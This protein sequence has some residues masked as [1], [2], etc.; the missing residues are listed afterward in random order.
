[1]RIALPLMLLFLPAIVRA[2]PSTDGLVVHFRAPETWTDVRIHFW[3]TQPDGPATRWPGEAMTPEGD[4]WYKLSLPGRR[5]ARFVISAAGV[6]RLQTSDL[7]ADREDWYEGTWDSQQRTFHGAFWGVDPARFDRFT[8]PH[9]ASKALVLSFDDGN[10]PDREL[11][12]LFNTVG[13][14]G[15]FNLNSGKLGKDNY[16]AAG[17]V[18]AL[19]A[20][21]EVATHSVDHPRLPDLPTREAIEQ[22]LVGDR[23]TLE[24]LVGAPV[25]GH[26]YPFG[27]YDGRVLDVLKSAGFAYAR[28]VP[29]T[30][31]F[32]LPPDLFQWM[33]TCHSSEAGAHA[34]RF[35]DAPANRLSL[36][37]VWG[38]AW[39]FF[40][41]NG[42][43]WT[44]PNEHWARFGA[45]LQKV[46]GRRDVWYARAVDVADYMNALRAADLTDSGRVVRNRGTV[47]LWYRSSVGV[48]EIAPGDAFED[49]RFS[50]GP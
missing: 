32:G 33:G 38:H 25:R 14:K 23:R 19:Y 5:A 6:P 44:T 20:G 18:A 45:F 43:T 42:Q 10:A 9:G 30:G 1:M 26:A 39:E 2:A 15:T 22:Q 41:W 46:A 49:P 37:F 48:V 34:Q 40:N 28:V 7:F 21:H 13:V 50:P 35:I 27:D 12:R 16:L 29:W 36:F 11:V 4:G 3:G 17:E 47:S 24:G 8:F 31:G